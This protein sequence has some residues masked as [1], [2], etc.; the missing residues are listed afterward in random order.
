[1][2]RLLSAADF[3]HA[4]GPER[5]G[6]DALQVDRE[7]LLARFAR[8]RRPIKVAL[9]DQRMLAGVGNLYAS[10]ILHQSRIDPRTRCDRIGRAE[11]IRLFD[12]IKDVLS[13]A[14]ELQGSTLRD[15]TYRIGH[16]RSGSYQLYHRVYHRAGQP[17]L[18][19]GTERIVRIVQAQRSTFFCPKCQRR[20]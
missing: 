4:F 1:V 3:R 17:C 14:I 20:A 8:R 16:N 13:K 18:R 10:E 19:C 7:T 11:W 12:A 5:L 9:L 15:G 2:A 6:P